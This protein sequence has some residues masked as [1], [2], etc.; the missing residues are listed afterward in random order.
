[1]VLLLV[2][3]QVP[4]AEQLSADPEAPVAELGWRS[5]LR[6]KVGV[7][8]NLVDV[9]SKP[10]FRLRLPSYFELSNPP[11]N[12]SFVPWIFW[13][14]RIQLEGLFLIRLNERAVAG[15]ALRL[16]H[17]SDHSSSDTAYSGY[18]NI[19]SIALLGSVRLKWPQVVVDA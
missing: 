5:S 1:T 15:A 6:A 13:R 9:G 17:E 18:I 12:G 2:L 14:A 19:N 3:A 4:E 16:E 8:P 7:A 10:R 11:R